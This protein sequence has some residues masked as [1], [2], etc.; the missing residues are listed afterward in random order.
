M[1]VKIYVVLSSVIA[2]LVVGL[3]IGC[4]ASRAGQA[5]SIDAAVT[6]GQSDLAAELAQ[7]KE[8]V[9]SAEEARRQEQGEH[10]A[11]KTELE[12]TRSDLE[13]ARDEVAKYSERSLQVPA[14]QQ[15]VEHLDAEAV[16]RAP[17]NP[18][19]DSTLNKLL[20]SAVGIKYFAQAEFHLH[21]P[22][23]GDKHPLMGIH[24]LVVGEA[25]AVLD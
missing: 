6:K 12:R 19:N 3:A 1:E 9:R 20:A 25:N 2:A 15:K 13:Q 7:V 24:E 21:V 23:L 17:P 22:L 10:S 18:L 11:V 4:F 8:R 5:A 14:L 16:G